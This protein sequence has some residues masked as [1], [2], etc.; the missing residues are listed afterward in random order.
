MDSQVGRVLD[1]L[2]ESGLEDDTIIVC[3]SDHSYHLGEEM[4][5]KNTVGSPPPVYLDV[6]R[7]GISKGPLM[8]VLPSC[9]IF[10]DLC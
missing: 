10:A 3:W 1:A 6:R 7:T 5:G 4:T 9:S 2:K 8:G